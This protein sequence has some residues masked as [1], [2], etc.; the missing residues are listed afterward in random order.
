MQIYKIE[1]AKH[2]N[3]KIADFE[4]LCSRSGLKITPQRLEIYKEL[5]NSKEHPSANT[6]EES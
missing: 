5:A 2:L 4:Q 1:P 6:L 3:Q